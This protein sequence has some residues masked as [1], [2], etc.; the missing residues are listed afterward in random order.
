MKVTA[1]W[2]T[3]LLAGLWT[4]VGALLFEA[5]VVRGGVPAEL[6]P[7]YFLFGGIPFFWIPVFLYVFG[8]SREGV[9]KRMFQFA[10]RGLCWIGGVALVLMPG[11]PL[12]R[13]LH[14]S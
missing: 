1:T 3:A 14:A 5:F 6:H 10:G 12:I 4:G 7:Y 2:R 13:S 9:I 11:L 8:S